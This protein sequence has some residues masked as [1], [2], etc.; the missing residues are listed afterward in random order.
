MANGGEWTEH[1]SW[2]FIRKEACTAPENRNDAGFGTEA[3]SLLKT[4]AHV[5][6]AEDCYGAALLSPS[7]EYVD[8]VAVEGTDPWSIFAR[9]DAYTAKYIDPEGFAIDFQVDETKS[10]IDASNGVTTSGGLYLAGERY[11]I[12]KC[13]EQKVFSRQSEETLSR[14]VKLTLACGKGKGMYIA[15]TAGMTVVALWK[16]DSDINGGNCRYYLYKFLQQMLVD[17]YID[18]LNG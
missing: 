14:S 7:G 15:K 8:A 12:C 13:Q 18:S 1:L 4:F 17:G 5:D 16:G 9:Q 6:G 10:L 3:E 11:R 2:W